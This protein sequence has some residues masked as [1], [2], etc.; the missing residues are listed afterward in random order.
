MTFFLLALL[1]LMHFHCIP[2]CLAQRNL[3][4]KKN[5]WC[6]TRLIWNF[7][8]HGNCARSVIINKRDSWA[9]ESG[10]GHFRSPT[11]VRWAWVILALTIHAWYD[12]RQKKRL[13][14]PW[15]LYKTS[16][17]PFRPCR[18]P[19]RSTTPKQWSKSASAKKGPPREKWTRWEATFAH[20]HT[21]RMVVW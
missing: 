12:V 9:K 7:L 5:L 21:R 6:F 15:R 10:C 11:T 20:T 17:P 13:R 18:S 19:R 1:L 14:L 16:R 8:L 3:L 2:L 4:R